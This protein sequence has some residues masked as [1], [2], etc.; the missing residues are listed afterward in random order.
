MPGAVPSVGPRRSPGRSPS[1]G[2]HAV[3]GVRL[4]RTGSQEVRTG[5]QEELNAAFERLELNAA[6]ER[7][8]SGAVAQ[9]CQQL[10]QQLQQQQ[11]Q[12][13]PPPVRRVVA[14]SRSRSLD[15]PPG[16]QRTVTN[17]EYR[18]QMLLVH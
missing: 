13:A 14:L 16:M 2:R 12:Q 1:P 7:L 18:F 6:F 10:Q 17:G 8:A 3:D 5:S 4:V 9:Q 15:R 11:Q